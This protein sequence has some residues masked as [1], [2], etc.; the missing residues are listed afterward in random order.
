MS[1]S[2]KIDWYVAATMVLLLLGSS[3]RQHAP[4]PLAKRATLEV[5]QVS[6]TTTPNS[7]AAIDSESGSQIFL[8]LPPL[9]TTADVATVQLGDDAHDEQALTINF[10]PKGAQNLLA[11]TTPAKLQELAI[12]HHLAQVAR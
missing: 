1:A 8:L 10:K 6:R 11:A 5:Y 2:K 12:R 7:K 4:K 9:I 3:C